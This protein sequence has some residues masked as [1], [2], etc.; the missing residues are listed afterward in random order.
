MNLIASEINNILKQNPVAAE[1]DAIIAMHEDARLIDNPVAYEIN[2]VIEHDEDDDVELYENPVRDDIC[3]YLVHYGVG[4][5]D[6]APGPGSGR[7]PKGS[8]DNPY[9]HQEDFVGKV[10]GL[11]AKGY[12]D[13]EIAAQLGIRGASGKPSSNKLRA[14]YSTALNDI[15]Y[16]QILKWQKLR[17]EG[18]TFEEI[19]QL[20]GAKNESTVRET[21]KK[22]EQNVDKYKLARTTADYLKSMISENPKAVIDVGEEANALIGVSPQKLEQALYLLEQ[23]GYHVYSNYQVQNQTNTS[24]YTTMKVLASPDIQYKDLYH[25]PDTGLPVDVRMIKDSK[26]V[27]VNNGEDIMLGFRYPE[28]LD[29]KRLQVVYAED[30]GKERDGLVELRKG[31]PDI[32]LG[33]AHYSQ[34]RILVDGTHYIKGMAVYADDL[35]EGIDVRFNTNKSKGTPVIGK[36]SS[37]LKPISSDPTN[38]FNSLIK[39]HGGQSEYIGEDGK[40]HLSL[41]NKRADQGDWTDW[42]DTLPSQFLSK[43]P[44]SLI[45]QQL[46]ISVKDREEQLNDILSIT[47]PVI[48]EDRL[49]SFADACDNAAVTLKAAPFPNQK[50][51]VILPIPSLSEKEVFAPQ[52]DDGT[53]LALVRYPHG[54]TF[55]IPIVTVNNKNKVGRNMIGLDSID[56]MGLNA[57]VAERLSGA[58]FDGDTVMAIPITSKSNI[59]SS[60]PLAGLK[61]FDPKERYPGVKDKN[62]NYI[63]PLLSKKDTGKEMGIVS[64]L[65]TD[66][67]IKGASEEE[68]ARA[69]RHSMVV[70]DAAKHSLDYK[71]SEYENDIEGLKKI[72]Q[73]N[74]D[75]QKGYGGASTLTVDLARDINVE[76]PPYPF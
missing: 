4:I 35:P 63:T 45:K 7:Y 40:K 42:S 59:K 15:K 11:R 3:E 14:E 53:T 54:G 33:D 2:S 61:D 1:I 66:M 18:K 8:G 39:E 49:I 29:S 16:H 74:S 58:D 75:N 23:E 68:L 46:S 65:I 21:L 22:Y 10:T 47:N 56:G 30:G 57:K 73:I 50:W 76:A 17:D 71:R 36:D 69:V 25:A 55:E 31:V 34:V 43:Q 32:S 64:N 51:H 62:G 41:I 67:T 52:Y 70:I 19:A 48:R 9:Q 24:N 38:P 44:K 20:T 60:N 13:A 5:D 12:T 26:R 6:G 72:Y 37:V 28:S 27:L